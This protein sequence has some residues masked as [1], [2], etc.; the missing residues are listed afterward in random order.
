MAVEPTRFDRDLPVLETV[1][2]LLEEQGYPGAFVQ[3]SQIAERSGIDAH[4]VMAALSAMQHT[5]VSLHLV[6]AGGDP[7]PQMVSGVTAEARR[8]VGQWQTPDAVTD[9]LLAALNEAA[10][11]E[12]DPA[13]RS[14]LRSAADAVTGIGRDVLVNVITA[15]ATGAIPHH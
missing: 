12:E 3:V 2:Q 9:R 10:E 1:I 13:K 15:A 11:H 6:F 7:Y 4:T 5:Y 8:V 14:R